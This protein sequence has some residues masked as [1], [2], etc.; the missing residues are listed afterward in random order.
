MSFVERRLHDPAGVADPGAVHFPA[1]QP[2]KARVRLN[3]A[4]DDLPRAVQHAHLLSDAEDLGRPLEAL[5]GG[6]DDFRWKVEGA[7]FPRAFAGPALPARD[8]E[9]ELLPARADDSMKERGIDRI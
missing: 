7:G 2:A 9:P 3:S 5:G 6:Y 1:R 4:D 8:T